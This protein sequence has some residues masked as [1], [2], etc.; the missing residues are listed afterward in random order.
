MMDY[1]HILGVP[2]KAS[3][4]DIK[5]A[6]RKLALKW[7]PDK[8]P[9]NKEQAEKKFKE[10]AEAYEVLSDGSRRE[11]YDRNDRRDADF[12]HPSAFWSTSFRDPNDVFRDFFQDDFGFGGRGF[13]GA[14]SWQPSNC[15]TWEFRPFSGGN[16]GQS[17]WGRVLGWIG[18]SS[19]STST[20]TRVVNG[21]SVTTKTMKANGQERTEIRENGV[22]TSVKI[23]GVEDQAARDE[24]QGREANGNL[25]TGSLGAEG[26]RHPAM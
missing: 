23:N 20:H 5:K 8:N 12:G 13:P 16:P 6:Y 21:R 18:L 19:S 26:R 3:S 9:D 4:E 1:Y 22:L 24:A 11:D 17:M 25:V 15:K 10:I 2:E 14:P 7:H